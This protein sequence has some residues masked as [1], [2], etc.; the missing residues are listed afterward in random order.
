MYCHPRTVGPGDAEILERVPLGIAR[1]AGKASYSRPSNASRCRIW[2][3]SQAL[4]QEWTC[5]FFGV[6][7]TEAQPG[8]EG[9]ERTLGLAEGRSRRSNRRRCR[10]GNG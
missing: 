3:D 6:A 8:Q 2:W 1:S 5:R 9:V 4:V 10:F 7:M